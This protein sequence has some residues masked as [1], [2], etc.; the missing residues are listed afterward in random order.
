MNED[1]HNCTNTL[2]VVQANER[3]PLERARMVLYLETVS[4]VLSYE[5]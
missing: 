5:V 3:R 2:R 4:E 1:E